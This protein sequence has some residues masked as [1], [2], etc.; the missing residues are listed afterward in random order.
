MAYTRRRSRGE[1]PSWRRRHFHKISPAADLRAGS[2]RPSSQGAARGSQS[3]ARIMN[4]IDPSLRSCQ[5][6]GNSFA[7]RL[8]SG[9]S[10]QRFCCTDCR[11][12]F[13]RERLRAQRTSL[14][15][16]QS[17]YE[18]AE[19]LIPSLTP[20]ERRRLIAALLGEVPTN[21]FEKAPELRLEP[22]APTVP[23]DDRHGFAEFYQVYPRHVA[24]GAAERAYRRIV[25]NG[26]ATE[27][28]LLAGAMRYAA[29]QDGK[30]PTYTKHPATWLN[31]KC[32]LDEPAPASAR[33]RSYL[34]SIRAGL[35]VHLDEEAA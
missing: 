17:L 10:A 26:E 23:K 7:P 34:D 30:D 4:V 3:G 2:F 8:G 13:H 35:A 31:G 25:K 6:C 32:W 19:R 16:G 24:R 29:A 20:D 1:A 12:S 11:L 18:Q 15:A 33:P 14:Y 5:E 27:A 28:D 22:A 9:G 21:K